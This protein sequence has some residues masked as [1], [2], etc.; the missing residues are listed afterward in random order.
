VKK[1]SLEDSVDRYIEFFNKK[2][3][4]I[5][6]S[7]FD[8][9]NNL[10]KKI[11]YVGLIGALSKTTSNSKRGNRDRIVSFIMHFSDWKY[12]ERISLPH[13]VKLLNKVPDPEFSKVREFSY[14]LFDKWSPGAEVRLNNDPTLKGIK[15]LWPFSI[16]KPL[17]NIKLE[18]LQHSNL[19]L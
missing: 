11:L 13:L 3:K 2:L 14:S 17:E 5:K 16:P 6:S 10:F 7:N 12:S 15:K 18:Y 8:D 9:A 19:F 4:T 1:L